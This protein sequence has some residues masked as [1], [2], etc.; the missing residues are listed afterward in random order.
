MEQL[1]SEVKNQKYVITVDH[2]QIQK[3]KSAY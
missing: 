3:N 2:E 1:T